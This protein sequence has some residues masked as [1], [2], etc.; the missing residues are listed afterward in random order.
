[1]PSATGANKR[2]R[3]STNRDGGIY[4]AEDDA[5]YLR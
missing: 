4:R 3:V 2:V 1:M 5:N